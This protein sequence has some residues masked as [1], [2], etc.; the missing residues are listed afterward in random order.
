MKL[1]FFYIIIAA[2]L[3]ISSFYY[4]VIQEE[5]SKG[6]GR[7]IHHVVQVIFFVANIVCLILAIKSSVKLNNIAITIIMYAFYIIPIVIYI[8]HFLCYIRKK[9]SIDTT[10]GWSLYV[11]FF[12]IIGLFSK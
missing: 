8:M 5:R 6:T 3:F 10:L 11:L 2:I 12:L 7:L 9:D 4:H 1:Y